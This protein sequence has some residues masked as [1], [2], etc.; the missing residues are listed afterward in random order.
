MEDVDHGSRF[1]RESQYRIEAFRASCQDTSCADMCR[2]F[3]ARVIQKIRLASPETFDEVQK[4]LQA[5]AHSTWEQSWLRQDGT[6]CAQCPE[7]ILRVELENTGSQKE[8]I[9]EAQDVLRMAHGSCTSNT[10][11][12]TGKRER[13]G[14]SK[15]KTRQHQRA[16]TERASH[17]LGQSTGDDF[18]P[19]FPASLQEERAATLSLPTLQSLFLKGQ[20]DGGGKETI[21][22]ASQDR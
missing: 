3:V 4:E 20:E 10:I 6:S 18:A 7:E 17:R 8:R 21:R 5:P 1:F 13:P 19:S 16:A 12:R 11:C 9:K 14:A 2:L 22:A 15:E